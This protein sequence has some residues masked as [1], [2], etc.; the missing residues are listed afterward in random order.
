[1]ELPIVCKFEYSYVYAGKIRN[2][3]LYAVLLEYN[4]ELDAYYSTLFEKSG[5]PHGKNC[6]RWLS[7]KD[8]D[9][10]KLAVSMNDLP[11]K[12]AE[13]INKEIAINEEVNRRCSHRENNK[14]QTELE[15]N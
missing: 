6:S 12:V 4:P 15:T 13:S 11:K 1:M 5:R 9:I 8:N 7:W 2:K 3:D 14:V 10:I